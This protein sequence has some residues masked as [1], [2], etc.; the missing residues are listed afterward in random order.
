MFDGATPTGDFFGQ[1]A[2]V[3]QPPTSSTPPPPSPRK[4]PA[5]AGLGAA[6]GVMM[7]ILIGVASR[8]ATGAVMGAIV[9]GLMVFFIARAA[10]NE[11]G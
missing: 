8:D 9:I 4:T 10:L 2:T 6:V 7:A 5:A 1:G 3:P 11:R